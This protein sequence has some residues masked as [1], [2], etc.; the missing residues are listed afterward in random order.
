MS[1]AQSSKSVTGF[2]NSTTRN[3]DNRNETSLKSVRLPDELIYHVLEVTELAP[4]YTH[5]KNKYV[6]HLICRKIAT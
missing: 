6:G 4:S 3:S 1:L 5:T 2:Q